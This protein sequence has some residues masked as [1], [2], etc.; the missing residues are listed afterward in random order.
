MHP[1]ALARSESAWIR[2]VCP[3]STCR[4]WAVSPGTFIVT[5]TLMSGPFLGSGSDQGEHLVALLLHLL[6]GERFEVE[7]E[8]RLRVRRAHVHVPVLGIDRQPVEVG[9]APLRGV[10]LLELLEL[11]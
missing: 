3:S 10:A 6:L 7:A 5:S 9:D 1:S 11:Q 4:N 8:E 2:S